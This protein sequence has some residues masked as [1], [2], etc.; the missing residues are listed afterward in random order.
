VYGVA[1]FTAGLTAF[2]M[3][4]LYFSIFWRQQPAHEPH[5]HEG[6]WNQKFPLLLLALLALS[7]GWIPFGKFISSDGYPLEPATD[8][9]MT[10]P[11]LVLAA[12]GISLSARFYKVKNDRPEK[13]AASLGG[14]YRTAS[15]KFYID[16]VYLFITKKIIFPLIGRPIAWID[17]NIVDGCMNGIARLTARIAALVKGMQSG[18]VQG[19]ALWFFGGVLVLT[20]LFVYLWK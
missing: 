2:Y 6:G 7:A 16:E 9:L 17:R 5:G 12:G 8:W 18:R 10:I 14:L 19:Y 4:R 15:R 13:L 11:P 20:C 3:F 1:L